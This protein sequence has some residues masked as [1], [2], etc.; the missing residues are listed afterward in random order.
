MKTGFGNQLKT[1]RKT[2]FQLLPKKGPKKCPVYPKLPW[3]G[4]ISLKFEKQVKSNVQNC[5]RAVD[6]RVIFQTRKILPS[7]YKDAVPIT[8]QTMV[9]HQ[10]VCRCDCRYV[11]RTYP[12][13]QHKIN[14]HFPKSIRNKGNPPT[15]LPKRNCKITTPLNQQDCDSAIGLHLI[16]NSDCACHYH[17]DQFCISV[18]ARTIFHLGTL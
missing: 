14:Q 8:H 4:N 2:H 6:P 15:V 9:I 1:E 16:Q 10:Y 7:I 17:I 5:F 12:R 18:K 11:G 13:L 3:I